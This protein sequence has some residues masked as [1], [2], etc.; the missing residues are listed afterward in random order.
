MHT[1]PPPSLSCEALDTLEE[2]APMEGE[3][4]E[5]LTLAE[6]PREES[7]MAVQAEMLSC[8][9]PCMDTGDR[10]DTDVLTYE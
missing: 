9:N 2:V 5:Q 10:L 6:E 1:A 7:V 4:E 3:L 8:E